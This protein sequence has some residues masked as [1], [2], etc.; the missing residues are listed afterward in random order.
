MMYRFFKFNSRK[1]EHVTKKDDQRGSIRQYI[2]RFLSLALFLSIVIGGYFLLNSNLFAVSKI[3]TYNVYYA[4]EDEVKNILLSSLGSN[5]WKLDSDDIALAITELPC[6]KSVHVGRRLPSTVKVVVQEWQPILLMETDN[7]TMALLD[8]GLFQKLIRPAQSLEMPLFINNLNNG[9]L[10]NDDDCALLKQLLQATDNIEF[11][12]KFPVD[13]I[14]LDEDGLNIVLQ[15]SRNKLVLGVEQFA[16]RL[17]RY[18][19][20]AQELADESTVDLR[21]EQQVYIREKS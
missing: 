17:E 7:S 13:F 3:E 4:D 9:S 2:I 10:P 21:F 1:K 5:I 6:I 19:I 20:V 11:D 8:N 18:L 12:V 15:G 14:I 16:Q